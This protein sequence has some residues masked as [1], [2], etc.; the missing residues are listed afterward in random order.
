MRDV[1]NRTEPH[2]PVESRLRSWFSEEV[3]AAESDIISRNLF[4]RR[5][6]SSSASIGLAAGLLAAVVAVAA[7]FRL[8]A[9]IS[10]P[11]RGN[12]AGAFTPSPS[13]VVT[14]WF[15]DGLPRSI[16]GTRVYRPSD[17]TAAMSGREVLVGGWDEGPLAVSC[18]IDAAG[19]PS[20]E[21]LGEEAAGQIVVKV[22][23]DQPYAIHGDAIVL[24]AEI[25][26]MIECRSAPSGGC[27]TR[28]YIHAVR[29]VWQG[30]PSH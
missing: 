26:P 5:P 9:P 22:R 13:T 28:P 10:D 30:S 7:M 1:V 14:A 27:P 2:G 12:A 24:L 29:I 16:D 3:A 18:P 25:D 17:V 11:T 4:H 23:W 6:H 15:P 21:G 20:F 19:C 8:N